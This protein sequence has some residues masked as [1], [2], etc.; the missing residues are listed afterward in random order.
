[1]DWEQEAAKFLVGKKITKVFYLEEEESEASGFLS[2]PFV[3]E[4][5]DGSWIFPMSDD[6][7]NNGGVLA[8]SNPELDTIPVI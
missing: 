3:I 4:F 8:T 5:D 6:E 7:G 2:R 1:M